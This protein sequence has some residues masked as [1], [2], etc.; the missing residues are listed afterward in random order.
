MKTKDE[1][2]FLSDTPSW[3]LAVFTVI[4]ATLVLFGLG[5]GV[6]QFFKIEE[7]VGGVVVYAIFDVLIALGCYVIV[8]QNPGSIWYVLLICNAVGIIA[9]I[10]E[11]NFWITSLWMIICAGWALSIIAAILG[12][13]AG[14][15]SKK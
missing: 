15:T 14:K 4:G 9:A 6:S 10:V 1:H 5:E 8:R 3:V 7:V 2:S 11:P 13:R 12:T